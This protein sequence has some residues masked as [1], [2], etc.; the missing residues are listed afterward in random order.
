MS[1]PDYT[2]FT[3]GD[4]KIE[5]FFSGTWTSKTSVTFCMIK[6]EKAVYTGYAVYKGKP[7]NSNYVEG[8]KIAF[9]RALDQIE[10]NYRN[11][12]KRAN[13]IF[14][15]GKIAQFRKEMRFKRWQT[16]EGANNPYNPANR[17]VEVSKDLEAVKTVLEAS[18]AG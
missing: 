16:M 2:S 1:D 11:E 5:V 8:K 14:Y 15:S 4:A 13:K 7:G 17:G 18:H 9:R 3:I 6:G 12:C 10:E